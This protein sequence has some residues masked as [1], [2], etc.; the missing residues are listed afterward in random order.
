MKAFLVD[1]EELATRRLKRM[2]EESGRVTVVGSCTDPT[3]ALEELRDAVFDVLFLD[4]H[5]PGMTGF[6]LLRRLPFEPL[7]VFTTAYDKHA[8][9]AF[10]VNSVDYLLKPVEPSH[11]ERAISKVERV[12]GGAEPRPEVQDL[13]RRLT[14]ALQQTAPPEYPDRLASKLGERLEFV[15]LAE[16]THLYAKDKLTFASTLSKDY[17]LDQTIAEL[18]DKLDPRRFVRI[19]RSTIVN[20]AYVRELYLWFA[21]KML[22]R[23]KDEKGTELT[24][25]RDRVKVLKERLGV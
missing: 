23:L 5:M 20:V 19:H 1:D 15:E 4:I 6:E 2:L 18:E 3:D 24:V 8:L 13:V 9:E 7:V 21:G 25:A 16:V 10:A 11:L 12:R 14:S 22:L 17:C